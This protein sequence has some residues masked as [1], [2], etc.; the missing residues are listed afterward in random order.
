MEVK[1]STTR[2]SLFNSPLLLGFDQFERVLDR[3]AKTS[4][5]NF[6]HYNIEQIGD[7]SI[8]ITLALAGF[9]IPDL[10]ITL[11]Q[12]QLTVRGRQE[13]DPNRRY[14]HR[15]IAARQFK[16]VFVLAD[17][18]KVVGANLQHGL[19][20]IDLV[21]E[22]IIHEVQEISITESQN[23]AQVTTDTPKE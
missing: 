14:I 11:E 18:L 1:L 20:F 21:R 4:G 7:D 9:T 19:L 8:R 10:Q 15:S 22:N 3:V 2:L 13:D 16:R 5:D 23:L 17:G 12:N 6:P